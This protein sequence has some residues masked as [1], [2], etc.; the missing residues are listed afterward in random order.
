MNEFQ[1]K[2]KISYNEPCQMQDQQNAEIQIHS[3]NSYKTI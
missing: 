2:I 3:I 1:N